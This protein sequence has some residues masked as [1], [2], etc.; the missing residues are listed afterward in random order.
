MTITAILR[1]TILRWA[2]AALMAL[3][4]VGCLSENPVGKPDPQSNDSRLLGKWRSEDKNFPPFD[5]GRSVWV[6]E[7][8]DDGTLKIERQDRKSQVPTGSR[9]TVAHV[10]RLASGDYL[11]FRLETREYLIAR[12]TLDNGDR[13][14]LQFVDWNSLTNA[15]NEQALP[16]VLKKE[17]SKTVPY[18]TATPKQWQ[19]FL[20]KAPPD[21]FGKSW[22][23]VR[24]EPETTVE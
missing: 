10:T 18:V 12:Y 11:N 19:A 4:L 8:I 9:P 1:R 7:A 13:L 22:T 21:L 14:S 6:V 17:G 16:G 15:I 3:A 23:F 2:A 24:P 20:E 5:Q